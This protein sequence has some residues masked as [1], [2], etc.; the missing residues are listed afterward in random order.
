[1][2]SLTALLRP[3]S[4]WRGDRLLQPLA[5]LCVAAALNLSLTAWALRAPQRAPPSAAQAAARDHLRQLLPEA[6]VDFDRITGSPRSVAAR[7][8]F[9]SGPKGAGRGIPPP[10]AAAVAAG[11]PNRAA[12]VLMPPSPSIGQCT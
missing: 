3:P 11:D 8:G 2:R 5:W 1:M 9:L 7:Q 6:Q 12:K 10:A 4:L